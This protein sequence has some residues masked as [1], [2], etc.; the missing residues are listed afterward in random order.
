ML[1]KKKKMKRKFFEEN[2][3]N[4]MFH[5]QLGLRPRGYLPSANTLK[6]RQDT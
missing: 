1:K 5:T 6:S 3:K 4:K 2:W